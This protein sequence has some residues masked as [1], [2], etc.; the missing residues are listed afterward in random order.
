MT[1][2]RSDSLKTHVKKFNALLRE[3]YRFRGDMTSTQAART[4]IGSLKPGYAVMIDIIYRIIKPLTHEKVKHELLD[5][6]EEKSFTTPAMAYANHSD[7]HSANTSHRIM[8]CTKE[9]C[10]GSTYQRPHQVKDCFKQP[11]NA[12]KREEWMAKQEESRKRYQK[13]NANS[14]SNSSIQGMKVVKPTGLHIDSSM[15]FFA[16]IDSENVLSSPTLSIGTHEEDQEAVENE[17]TDRSTSELN[18]NKG[19]T[20]GLVSCVVP[21]TLEN[22]NDAKTFEVIGSPDAMSYTTKTECSYVANGTEF[23]DY[24]Q[25]AASTETMSR[26]WAL[27]ETGASHHMF[28]DLKLFQ[29]NSIKTIDGPSK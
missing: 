28:N 22:K 5:T 13:R 7:T 20:I 27:N 1:Q 17:M 10:I 18:L 3:F 6:D 21:G 23:V 14:V 29:A 11:E 15:M 24:D 19:E 16:Y 8:R 4:L 2:H 25:L 12:E 9:V 26:L